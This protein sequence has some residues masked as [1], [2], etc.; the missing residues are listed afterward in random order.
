L[1]YVRE[2]TDAVGSTDAEPVSPTSSQYTETW[3]RE[4]TPLRMWLHR[5]LGEENTAEA[6]VSSATSSET[7]TAYIDANVFRASGHTVPVHNHSF[8]ELRESQVGSEC[9]ADGDLIR[10]RAW[11]AFAS[12]A[13][14]ERPT[15]SDFVKGMEK[16]EGRVISVDDEFFT[17]E[18]TPITDPQDPVVQADFS[19]ELIDETIE[20]GDVVYVTVRTVTD[21]RGH[22]PTRTAV[23]R[24]RRLGRWSAADVERIAE[25]GRELFEILGEKG[26]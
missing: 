15:A 23:V 21:E 4:N 25:R 22:W 7:V 19:R 24:R 2:E 6:R 1:T 5:T 26:E 18:L 16:W 3:L 17:A 11:T 10:A 13:A 9:D 8:F 12:V 20:A 14:P